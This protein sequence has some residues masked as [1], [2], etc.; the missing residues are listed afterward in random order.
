MFVHVDTSKMQ[1]IIHRP[2]LDNLHTRRKKTKRVASGCKG[3]FCQ[4]ENA[5][6]FQ[7]WLLP[8]FPSI[9]EKYTT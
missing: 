6:Y 1:W 3:N 9:S 8:L 4:C 5:K 7:I 2:D